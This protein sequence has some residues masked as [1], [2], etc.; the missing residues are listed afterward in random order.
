LFRQKSHSWPFKKKKKRKP[1]DQ[2][3]KKGKGVKKEKWACEPQKK[4][5]RTEVEKR[6]RALTKQKEGGRRIFW[7]KK[8]EAF[9]RTR[10]KKKKGRT[11]SGKTKK[12]SSQR[13]K[14][15]NFRKKINW[16][17]GRLH[18]RNNCTQKGERGL[19]P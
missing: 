13:R 11:T 6:G 17:R 8:E 15:K 12:E 2:P 1:F 5:D 9:N 7:R 19:R 3:E 18:P 14:G 10:K 16:L 4:N